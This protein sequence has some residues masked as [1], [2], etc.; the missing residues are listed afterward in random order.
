MGGRMNELKRDIK[1]LIIA[2]L[3]LTD[4]TP[5]PII[6]DAVSIP[7]EPVGKKVFSSVAAL[8]QYVI[9]HRSAA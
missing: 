7:D 9:E 1:E 6:D 4:V 8:A 5:D 3:T 2:S